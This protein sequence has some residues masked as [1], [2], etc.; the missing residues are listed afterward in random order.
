MTVN[1]PCG[2]GHD[3]TILCQLAI[4]RWL[5]FIHIFFLFYVYFKVA[6]KAQREAL[7]RC[8]QKQA[9][10]WT[11]KEENGHFFLLNG[12]SLTDKLLP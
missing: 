7:N 1:I 12:S 9:G 6:C 2:R 4:G 5:L 8:M 10:Y 11:R 3:D